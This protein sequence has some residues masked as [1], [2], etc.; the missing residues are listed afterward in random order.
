MEN[1]ELTLEEIQQGSFNILKKIKEIFDENGWKYYLAYGTLLGAIRHKGFIPWDDDIDIWVPRQD[2]EKFLEYC[3]KNEK[4]LFPY[5]IIHYT[6]NNKYIYTIARFSDSRYV[7]DYQN[8][9][10]YGLGLFVDIY[11]LDG[12]NIEDIGFM[13][14]LIRKQ[15]NINL[16]GSKEFVKSKNLIKNILK[17]PYFCFRKF[18][19]M[20][21][22]LKE[23][24]IFSQKYSY[25][26]SEYCDSMVWNPQ[27]SLLKKEWFGIEKEYFQEFNGETFRIPYE[28]DK[29]LEKIY[30]DYMQLPPE[31]KRIPH[32]FYKAYKK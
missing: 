4:L 22:M 24:D 20:S 25:E 2:Y 6:T 8:V 29:V 9:D 5:E 19:N 10:D 31:E 16:I 27:Y 11:P 13:K 1:R 26:N 32:H 28:Y 21:K 12:I 30:G 14:K 17:Y 18:F 15:K 3:R 7:I 23:L